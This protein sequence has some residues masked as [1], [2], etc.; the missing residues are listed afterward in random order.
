MTESLF[1]L[2]LGGRLLAITDACVHPADQTA[3]LPRIGSPRMPDI[4]QIAALAPELVLACDDG[5]NAPEDI[6]ALRSA[7]LNVWVNAPRT[8][9]DV[10]NLLWNTMYLFDETAMVPRVR[11]L[12]YMA[13]WLR[14]M[15]EQHQ[16]SGVP[17]LRV[18]VAISGDPLRTVSAQTYTHDLLVLCGADNVFAD[19][20]DRWPQVTLDEVRA[21]CPDALLLEADELGA[22]DRAI[23]A[24]LGVPPERIHLIDGSLLT[25]PGTRIARAFELLPSL[26]TRP[27]DL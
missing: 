23:F 24:A 17:A 19:H 26:L 27:D 12:E 20:P 14:A 3:G 5:V 1:E 6:A 22:G 8:V 15:A 4:A 13:D 16:Q 21:A 2:G 7:G 18:F 9:Q 25:W 11:Q 10:F